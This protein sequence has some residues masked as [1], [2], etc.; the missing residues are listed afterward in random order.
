MGYTAKD[1]WL[2][3]TFNKVAKTITFSGYKIE[4]IKDIAVITDV[5]NWKMIYNFVKTTWTFNRDT[6][7]LTLT[8]DTNIAEFSNTDELV[9]NLLKSDYQD[10]QEQ[11]NLTKS[12][13][14]T[15]RPLHRINFNS[16]DQLK[17]SV[18]QN[19]VVNSAN[20][21]YLSQYS[22][23]FAYMIPIHNK[24]PRQLVRSQFMF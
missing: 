8:Y 1:V 24:T 6:Q 12:I 10:I 9:I 20:Y 23:D 3:Y 11:K 5:T 21:V 2:N 15:I 19:S 16:L 13:L 14:N 4:S 22:A 17:V 18:D 7:V